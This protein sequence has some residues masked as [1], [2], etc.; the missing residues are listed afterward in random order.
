[1]ETAVP[2]YI[3]EWSQFLDADEE[4][5]PIDQLML[6]ASSIALVRQSFRLRD[7]VDD[8]LLATAN[9]LEFNLHKW[10]EDTSTNAIFAYQSV[11]DATSSHSFGGI[12]HEYGSPHAFRYWNLWRVLRI[13]LSR[14]QEALWRR[15][16]PVLATPELPIPQPDHFRAIRNQMVNDICV[17]TCSVFG[18][19]DAAQPP[20]G[21]VAFGQ[22]LLTPLVTAGTVLLEALAEL[23]ISPGGGRLILLDRPYHLDPYNQ[24]STQLAWIIQ[25]V[26]YI[27]EKVGIRCAKSHSEWL[28]GGDDEYFDLGRS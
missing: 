24:T 21:S 4:H 16:W 13:L 17:T 23:T 2:P 25:K 11:Q 19:D 18:N 6:I 15:S 8:E 20:R 27:A 14:L 3:V 5:L 22:V 1:M 10:A 12:R 9:D 26:D 7:Q 28:K